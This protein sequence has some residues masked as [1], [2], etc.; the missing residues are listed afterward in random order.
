MEIS[1]DISMNHMEIS[2]AAACD[3]LDKLRVKTES[4]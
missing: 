2:I 4:S 3:D 1:M